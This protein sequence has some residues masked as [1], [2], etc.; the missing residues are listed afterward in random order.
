[1]EDAAQIETPKDAGEGVSGEVCRWIKEIDL[2]GRNEKDWR[3]R[4]LEVEDEYRKTKDENTFNILWANTEVL[5]PNVYNSTPRPDVRRRF[6]DPDPT[7]KQVSEVLKRGIS[8]QLDAYDFDDVITSAILD[9][10]LPGR[11]IARIQYAPQF[12]KKADETEEYDA[13]KSVLIPCKHVGWQDFRRGH[14]RAW[15]EV[16]W[17]AYR[18]LMTVDEF[19]KKFP[20]VQTKPDYTVGGTDEQN[21]DKEPHLFKRHQVW[22]IWD[23]QERKIRWLAEN[24]EAN[25]LLV[26]DDKLGLSGF[27]DTPRP[28]YAVK[29]TN[30]LIPKDEYGYYENQ[31]KE[32]NLITKRINKLTAALKVRGIYDATIAEAANLLKAGDNEMIA[33]G[34]ATP[35]IKE[36]GMDRAFWFMPIEQI[37]KVLAQL[38]V[39]R[40]QVRSVIYE[41]VGIAD[42]MRGSSDPGETLGAQQLKAQTGSVRMRRRQKEVQRYVRDLFQMMAEIMAKHMPPE[43]LSAMSG[44]QVTPEMHSL[45]QNNLLMAFRIDVE[46]DS[47]VAGDKL[48]EREAVVEMVQGI[49][50]F[51]QSI[52][53]AVDS[54]AIPMEAAKEILLAAVRRFDFGYAVEEAIGN[55]EQ[56]AQQQPPQPEKP[57]PEQLAAEAENQRTQAEMQIKSAEL[58]LKQQE[59]A[60]KLQIEMIKAQNEQSNKQAELV[61][62]Q[63]EM[64]LKE[65]ELVLKNRE[66]DLKELQ[67]HMGIADNERKFNADEQA[68]SREGDRADREADAKIESMRSAGEAGE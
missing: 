57:S 61:L 20:N 41:I 3:K 62:K 15:D 38:Y 25:F 47:T 45:M 58:Q 63:K 16:P 29:S 33:S 23:K 35:A 48:A 64:A 5:L 67:L 59:S 34:N 43:L 31:A 66:I 50:S 32:L 46:T 65:A 2:A 49:G 7:A 36:G 4:G 53:P 18:H 19:K 6:N 11:G 21:A 12:E 26:E 14:G 30:T 55:A 40:D 68:R 24:Y 44:I 60:Q 52:A 28:L 9:L 17:V 10:L 39:Q 56:Q 13:L 51:V 42:I 22:E 27:F 37:A 1:M 8:F 54:G